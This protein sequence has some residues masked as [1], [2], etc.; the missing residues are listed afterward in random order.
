MRLATIHA[1]T[2]TIALALVATPAMAQNESTERSLRTTTM[3]GL[4]Q[5]PSP[6]DRI[7]GNLHEIEK[8]GWFTITDVRFD[9]VGID[10]QQ[11]V[12]W[13]LRVNQ[14]I[15]CRHAV[16]FLRNYRDVRFYHETEQQALIEVHYTRLYYDH[17]IEMG[18]ANNEV[19]PRDSIVRLYFFLVRGD[20][21]RIQLG[22]P[23]QVVVTREGENLF[24][25]LDQTKPKKPTYEVPDYALIKDRKV[26]SAR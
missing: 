3:Q 9:T 11:S 4:P 6:L 8:S 7:S 1:L 14:P 26:S 2:T 25:N 20:L 17:M 13:T 5:L 15:T 24:R 21:P 23:N 12:V 22:K 10:R 19:L 16:I 18:A